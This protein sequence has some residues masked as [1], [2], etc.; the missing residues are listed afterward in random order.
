MS[1]FMGF[2]SKGSRV[3]I[4]FE[5][6]PDNGHSTGIAA[7]FIPNTFE[8]QMVFIE[9][10]LTDS[11]E[12]DPLPAA[13]ELRIVIDTPE[14]VGKGKLTVMQNDVMVDSENIPDDEEWLYFIQ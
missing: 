13:E 7:G 1:G 9:P 4:T 12:I 3:I 14:T 8:P 5:A 6:D 10:G 2:L 11:I